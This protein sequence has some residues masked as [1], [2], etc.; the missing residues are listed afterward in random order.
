MLHCSALSARIQTLV[1]NEIS[2]YA[3]NR[4][5]RFLKLFPYILDHI[6][7]PD[8]MTFPQVNKATLTVNSQYFGTLFIITI[9]MGSE[10][11]IFSKKN[12]LML[13]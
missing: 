8:A 1:L 2:I 3:T 13:F 12:T 9:F 4:F 10:W 5:S 11:P 6:F 7:A